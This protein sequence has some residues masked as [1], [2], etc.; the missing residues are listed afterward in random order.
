MLSYDKSGVLCPWYMQK[1]I[2]LSINSDNS[3]A[4]ILNEE[5]HN[6]CSRIAMRNLFFFNIISVFRQRKKKW[7][8]KHPQEGSISINRRQVSI[9]Y[10]IA[11]EIHSQ[12]VCINKIDYNNV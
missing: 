4:G 7:T 1:I 6:S 2:S 3:V 10:V 8:K 12:N 9:Q 11:L 5:E